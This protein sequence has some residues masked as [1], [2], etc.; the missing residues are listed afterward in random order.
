MEKWEEAILLKTD[1]TPRK[2]SLLSWK[3]GS[4]V[5]GR[6]RHRL[7]HQFLVCLRTSLLS[8][9]DGSIVSGRTRHEQVHQFAVCLRTGLLSRKD[10]SSVNGRTRYGIVR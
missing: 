3:D 4:R 8:W 1:E 2:W 7:V 10:G 9:K 6:T 5:S